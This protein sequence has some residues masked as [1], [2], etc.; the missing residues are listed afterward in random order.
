M[1]TPMGRRRASLAPGGEWV[2]WERA[3]VLA[4][5]PQWMRTQVLAS[6]VVGAHC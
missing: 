5:A 6:A 1:G 3:R 4:K 2:R